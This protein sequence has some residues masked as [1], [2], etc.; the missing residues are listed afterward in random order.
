MDDPHRHN[1]N[2]KK[3]DTKGPVHFHYVR[4]EHR[5]NQSMVIEVKLELTFVGGYWLSEGTRAPSVV[6]NYKYYR[7]SE[8]RFGNVTK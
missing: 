5:Q 3:P 8:K 6:L 1:Q 7:L 4:D 2:Q